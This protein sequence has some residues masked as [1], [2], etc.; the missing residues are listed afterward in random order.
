MLQYKQTNHL[1]MCDIN[2][3]FINNIHYMPKIPK[4]KNPY[5]EANNSK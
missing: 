3:S 4:F 5:A 1:H 2:Y